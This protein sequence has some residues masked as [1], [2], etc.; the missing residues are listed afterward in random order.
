M[1]TLELPRVDGVYDSPLGSVCY[2]VDNLAFSE[3]EVAKDGLKAGW[4]EL[5]PVL[6]AA[7][8]VVQVDTVLKAPASPKYDKLL[9]SDAYNFNSRP[10]L[11]VT[12]ETDEAGDQAG[13]GSSVSV[14]GIRTVMKDIQFAYCEFPKNWG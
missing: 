10:Y 13:F 11:K 6:K 1:S 8:W 3:F 14:E 7:A 4:C 2:H 5:K 12:N 9:S